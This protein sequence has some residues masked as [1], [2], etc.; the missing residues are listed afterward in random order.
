MSVPTEE[1]FAA[2]GANTLSRYEAHHRRLAEEAGEE[3]KGSRMK[4]ARRLSA[5][6]TAKTQPLATKLYVLL[7]QLMRGLSIYY[8][9]RL[10]LGKDFIIL[11]HY[12]SAEEQRQYLG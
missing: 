12:L 11:A 6:G 5:T 3:A 1:E 2:V 4:K 7:M 9:G 8:K 10:T